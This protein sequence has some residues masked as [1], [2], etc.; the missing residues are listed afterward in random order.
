M[1][2]AIFGN[3]GKQTIIEAVNNF[4]N[5]LFK[6]KIDF[7][8]SEDLRFVLSSLNLH[9]ELFVDKLSLVDSNVIFTFGGDGTMLSA[10][11]LFAGYDI[12]I[13]GINLGRLGFLAEFSLESLDITIDEFLAGTYKTVKR[14]LLSARFPGLN[15]TENLIALNDIVIDKREEALMLQIETYINGDYIGVY[16]SDGLIIATP[17]GSTAYSLAVGGPVIEPSSK[18]FVI[19]PIAPHMLTARPLVVSDTSLLSIKVVNSKSVGSIS[20]YADGQEKRTIRFGDEILINKYE[21]SVY[22]VKSPQV[23]YWDVLRAKLLWGREPIL[24]RI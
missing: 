13:V 7:V 3:P 24:N 21:K 19:A 20:V 2:I 11:R 22:L 15:E 12:P 9:S 14:T 16:N 8:I 10:G 18:V 4:T 5:L 17:T 23:T 1:K 6:R